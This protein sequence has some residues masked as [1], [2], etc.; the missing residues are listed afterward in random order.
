MPTGSASAQKII[1]HAQG[2]GSITAM[3]PALGA[4]KTAKP[5]RA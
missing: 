3:L 5:G 2:G 4:L 1:S